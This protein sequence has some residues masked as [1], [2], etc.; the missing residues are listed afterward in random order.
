MHDFAIE[1]PNLNNEKTHLD[2]VD[3]ICNPSCGNIMHDF[4]TAISN[5]T[6]EKLDLEFINEIY[7]PSYQNVMDDFVIDVFKP[8]TEKP[9]NFADKSLLKFYLCDGKFCY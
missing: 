3:E 9:T 4:A 6:S 5:P 7:D 1:I 2:F 8:S